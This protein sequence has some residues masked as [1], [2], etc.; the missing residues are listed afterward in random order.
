MCAGPVSGWP[1]L[2]SE[3]RAVASEGLHEEREGAGGRA[4]ATGEHLERHLAD[5]PGVRVPRNDA[6]VEGRLKVLLLHIRVHLVNRQRRR[7]AGP[8]QRARDTLGSA[9]RV[10]AS[11][12]C[13]RCTCD[14]DPRVKRSVFVEARPQHPQYDAP[15]S[16]ALRHR[17]LGSA[18]ILVAPLRGHPP[19]RQGQRKAPRPTP[20]RRRA[21]QRKAPTN[22]EL[23][24]PSRC[25]WVVP[26]PRYVPVQTMRRTAKPR[27]QGSS[28]PGIY[29][30]GRT[31]PTTLLATS[32]HL[33][34]LA[35]LR[36][37]HPSEPLFRSLAWAVGPRHNFFFQMD[38]SSHR[39][40]G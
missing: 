15:S 30:R 5:G 35:P 9:T 8:L 3:R 39:C 6:G 10:S 23:A 21:R 29:A 25:H 4:V 2:A 34:L 32:P 18:Q 11:R 14:S 12:V 26:T 40:G 24:P 28:S 33:G 22:P 31:T 20:G 37:P 13:C 36:R 1:G 7:E 38:D 27:K 17:P 16:G 19:H